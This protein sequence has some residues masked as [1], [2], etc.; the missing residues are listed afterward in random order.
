MSGYTFGGGIGWLDASAPDIAAAILG[1]AVEADAPLIMME[2]RHV[3]GAPLRR[4]RA[5]TAPPGGFI[6]HAV[7]ALGRS[8]REAIDAGYARARD[9]WVSADT[10]VT[11]GSWIE[12]APSVA[13]ALTPGERATVIADTVDPG[14]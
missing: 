12:G 4:E 8:T 14:R 9:I 1:T 6:Y 11:P 13:S 3:V 7:G 2:I 5:V 10:G